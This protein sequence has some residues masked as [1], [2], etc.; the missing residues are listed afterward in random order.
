MSILTS[1]KFRLSLSIFVVFV[2]LIGA[3]GFAF[4]RGY[5]MHFLINDQTVSRDEFLHLADEAAQGEPIHFGC[6]QGDWTLG[7]F[8]IYESHCF[9][10]DDALNIYM[11]QHFGSP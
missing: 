2:L 8:Y 6:A 3:F 9:T 1:K 5:F 7:W 11:K 10:S 4:T